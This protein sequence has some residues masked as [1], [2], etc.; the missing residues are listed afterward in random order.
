[1]VARATLIVL[2][3][4]LAALAACGPSPDAR[5]AQAD[6]RDA[7]GK[8]DAKHAVEL[9]GTWR[10]KRGDDD[11][12]ALRMMATTTLWRGLGASSAAIRTQSIQAIERQKIESLASAVAELVTSED[13]LV[14]AAAASALLTA[15]PSAPGVLTDLLRSEDGAARA[16]AVDGIGR[17]AGEY[18]RDD[19]VAMLRDP[20]P[21]VRRAAIGAIASFAEDDDLDALAAMATGDKDG[22]V[23]ARALRAVTARSADGRTELARRAVKDAYQ[24]VRQAAI[25]LL[26]RDRS[27]AARAVLVELAASPDP[28]LALPAAAALLR[29]EEHVAAALAVL[30]RELH[31]AAWTERAAA[32]N[33]AGAAPHADAL[34]IGGRGIADARA[35]VRL[36]AA[37][38]LL[39]LGND[40]RAR[41]ELGA[42]LTAADPLVRIDAA[43][44]LVRIGDPRGA[45]VMDSLARSPKLDVRRAAIAAHASARR[46]TPGLVAALA[47]ADPTL[48]ITAAELILDVL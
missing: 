10:A 14:A 39:H 31:A 42:A 25:D 47:D 20:D 13:D 4:A 38:L 17:G 7:L 16:L 24:G 5:R 26:A 3:T 40:R 12:D 8:G 1:M 23:R 34:R 32:L 6:M 30:D 33:A 18:A 15:H 36:A 9:Y 35:E 41:S 2:L 44:D 28:D 46:V 29:D 22:G 45:P 27:D 19:L 11:P 21:R 43:I 37:R 48:R